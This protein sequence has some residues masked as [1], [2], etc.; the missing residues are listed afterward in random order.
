MGGD[1]FAV[2]LDPVARK[3]DAV[4]LASRLLESL[5]EP[6]FHNGH[7]VRFAA[8]IGVVFVGGG[9]IDIEQLLREADAA[10]YRAKREGRSRV[11]VFQQAM[12]EEFSA[13][14]PL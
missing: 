4:H 12:H 13:G 5:Q 9:H 8:S 2:L 10:M 6:A 14:L 3:V 7:P 1:E 11:V